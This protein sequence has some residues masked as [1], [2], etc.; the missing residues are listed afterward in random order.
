MLRSCL[1]EESDLH[2]RQKKSHILNSIAA[3]DDAYF[4]LK[5]AA[6]IKQQLNMIQNYM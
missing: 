2:W 3:T 5:T 6:I 4:M 1:I